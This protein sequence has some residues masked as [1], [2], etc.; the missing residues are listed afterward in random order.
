MDRTAKRLPPRTIVD[1]FVDQGDKDSA[2]T[3]NALWSTF[4]VATLETLADGASVLAELWEAAW[5]KGGGEQW[6]RELGVRDAATLRDLYC[7]PTFVAS[8]DLDHIAS[9]LAHRPVPRK[10]PTRSTDRIARQESRPARV[11]RS[12]RPRRSRAPK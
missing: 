7:D 10:K 6:A 9:V 12:K 8:V 3:Q 1:R 2:A 4:K 11:L 5:K